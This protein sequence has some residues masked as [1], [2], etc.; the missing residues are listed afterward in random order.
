MKKS[1]NNLEKSLFE[2][3]RSLIWLSVV[4]N[5]L[6]CNKNEEIQSASR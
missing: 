2:K 4:S 1:E 3:I 5:E 6:R